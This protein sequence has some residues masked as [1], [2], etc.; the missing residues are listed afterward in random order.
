M[1][2][3]KSKELICTL[4]ISRTFHCCRFVKRVKRNF[5]SRT[6]PAIRQ[7]AIKQTTSVIKGVAN[8]LTKAAPASGILQAAGAATVIVATRSLLC[9]LAE[10]GSE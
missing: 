9:P 10:S 2:E 1:L 4:D 5:R 7:P 3:I 8:A 6:P